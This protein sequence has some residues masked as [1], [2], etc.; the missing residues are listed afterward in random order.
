[1]TK[2]RWKRGTLVA[3]SL[4]LALSGCVGKERKNEPEVAVKDSNVTAP[5]ELPI[6]KDKITLRLGTYAS[7]NIIDYKTN[8]YTKFLEEKTG[9]D[10]EFDVIVNPEQKIKIMLAANDKLP[11]LLFGMNFSQEMLIKYGKNGT[12]AL[13]DLGDYMDNYGYYLD[14]CLS[15]TVVPNLEKRLT[16]EDGGRYFMPGIGEQTGNMYCLKAFINKKWLD[17]LGLEV[18]KTTEEFKNVMHRFVNE[19]P[20]GNGK[21]DEIGITGC[22]NGWNAIPWHFFVNSFIYD[23]IWDEIIVDDNNKASS[24][25]YT[26][27]FKEALKYINELYKDGAYDENAFTQDSAALRMQ[28][29]NDVNTIGCIVASDIDSYFANAPEKILDYVALPPLVGPE[30]VAYAVKSD[31]NV[32]TNGIMTKYCQ[33]RLAAFRLMDYM[34]SEEASIFSR[35][36]VEGKDWKPATENDRS[37]FESINAKPRIVSIL[38]YGSVQNSNWEE[39]NPFFRSLSLSDGM[40]WNGSPYDGEKFKGDALAVYYGKEFKNRMPA[41]SYTVEEQEEKAFLQTDLKQH[42]D[43]EMAKFI[44]GRRSLDEYDKFLKEL[45]S[46]EFARYLKIVQSGIDRASE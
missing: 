24:I 33:N 45:D 10:F 5:G 13:V 20:N 43:Q 40:A 38:P 17:K 19:D 21:K 29:Q 1:M 11:D 44:L 30:G 28:C 35:F 31:V 3:L 22:T 46:L 14:E 23:D 41:T 8:E 15:K 32:V 7:N 6:V 4:A 37:V 26:K 27:E 12:G 2:S 16:T 25:L 9:I 39:R 34:L 42:I 36:G 18:P